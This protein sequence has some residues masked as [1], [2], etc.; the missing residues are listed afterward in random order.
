MTP[1]A[2]LAP[3]ANPWSAL[4]V[5][6][7]EGAYL[8]VYLSS[9]FARLPIR[10]VTRPG[11]NKSDPNLETMTYGLFSTCEPVMR[12]SIASRRIGQIFFLTNRE[13]KGR[14][15][16]GMY[17]LGWLV[18]VEKGDFALAAKSARFIDPIP[19]SQVAG[20]AG[21]A[22]QTRMRAFMQASPA[23]A[24]QLTKLLQ[25][26]PD[27]TR[28]YLAE[29]TRLERMSQTRTGYRYPSWDRKDP[30]DWAAAKPYLSNL[31]TDPPEKNVSPTGAWICAHCG[32]RIVN[33]SRLKICNSCGRSGTLK[34]ETGG[35]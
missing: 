22:V 20:A 29:I 14:A 28:D 15:L 6:R 25:Q 19:V 21:K 16:V 26:A 10:D 30:F 17:D 13:G 5:D 23:V 8:S 35:T 2:T 31:S 4:A 12:R 9:P 7:G 27:R 24:R 34:P 32:A 1:A 18:E 33:R 3:P 11:D